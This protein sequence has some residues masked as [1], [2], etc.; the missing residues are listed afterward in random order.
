MTVSKSDLGEL[1]DDR[2]PTEVKPGVCRYLL[3][4]QEFEDLAAKLADR[5]VTLKT[6]DTDSDRSGWKCS[7]N[8]PRKRKCRKSNAFWHCFFV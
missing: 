7:T 8:K 1:L 5:G 3:T 6:E 2:E 4:R